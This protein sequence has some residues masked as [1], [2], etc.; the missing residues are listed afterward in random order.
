M[1]VQQIERVSTRGARGETADVDGVE[2][3]IGF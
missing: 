3:P 1:K 2:E